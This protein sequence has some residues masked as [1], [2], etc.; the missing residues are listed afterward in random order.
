[1]VEGSKKSGMLER[2]PSRCPK[3]MK[4]EALV[5]K[6]GV[7]TAENEPRKGSRQWML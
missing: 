5:A 7:D 2:N 6:N 3:T 1:M 4:S